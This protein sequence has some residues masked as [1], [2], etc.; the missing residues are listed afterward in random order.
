MA[1]WARLCGH[2]PVLCGCPACCAD[3][4]L[5]V[6][7]VHAEELYWHLDTILPCHQPH[8]LSS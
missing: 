4:S 2:C 5:A 6:W 8:A 7:T 3:P 1:L